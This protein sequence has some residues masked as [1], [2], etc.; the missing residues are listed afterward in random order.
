VKPHLD[1]RGEPISFEEAPRLPTHELIEEFMLVANQVVG[2]RARARDLPFLYRVHE[3]PRY[4]KLRYF[5]ET[6]RYLGRQGPA[7]IVT[8]AKQ[9]RHWVARG[10]SPRDRLLNQGLLR[11]LEKARYDLVD[12]GHFGLGMQGYAHFTS[13]IRRYPDLANHRMV[14]RYLIEAASGTGDP[15]AFAADW[16]TEGVAADTSAAEVAADDA[17]RA[18]AKRKAVRYA[19][20]RVGEAAAGTI[21]GLTPAGLF[22]SIA[23]WNIEG[24]LPKRSLGDPSLTLAEHGFSFRSKRSRHRFGLGDSISVVVARADLDRREVELGLALRRGP[25]AERRQ[26]ARRRPAAVGRKRK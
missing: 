10:R 4:D 15:W 8:D 12:V 17:E 24:F 25:G 21:V 11:A 1:A 13:P 7:Q 19:L 14:K 18:V 23:E 5:F 22:V 3:R 6:A 26:R 16:L 2:Q 20:Q 9:L